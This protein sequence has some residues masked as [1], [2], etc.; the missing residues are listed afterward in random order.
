MSAFFLFQAAKEFESTQERFKKQELEY[1]KKLEDMKMAN[2]KRKKTM[3][4]S[5]LEKKNY[6]R[7]QKVPEEN[8]V[9]NKWTVGVVV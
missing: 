4:M 2:A 1:A 3:A 5:D 6:E 8:K 7:L 9:N